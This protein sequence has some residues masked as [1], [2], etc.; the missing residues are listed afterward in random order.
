MATP[1]DAGG[2]DLPS[3]AAVV[4][5]LLDPSSGLSPTD[6]ADCAALTRAV[7]RQLRDTEREDLVEAYRA[8]PTDLDLRGMLTGAILEC[9]DDDPD[10]ARRL[11]QLT[12]SWTVSPIGAPKLVEPETFSPSSIP[13]PVPSRASVEPTAFAETAFAGPAS[14]AVTD[15]I[16][17]EVL[18]RQARQQSTSR[19]GSS[20][21]WI[22]AFEGEA[23]ALLSPRVEL[24]RRIMRAAGNPGLE[25][26]GDR[27]PGPR[28]WLIAVAVETWHKD[29]WGELQPATRSVAVTPNDDGFHLAYDGLLS[30]SAPI[31]RCPDRSQV[32][33][34]EIIRFSALGKAAA[35]WHRQHPEQDP[36]A[37]AAAFAADG[38]RRMLALLCA[39]ELTFPD[40]DLGEVEWSPE[41]Q[42]VIVQAERRRYETRP[43]PDM[44]DDQVIDWIE[45]GDT[46]TGYALPALTGQQ[47][48]ALLTRT[49]V[50]V[51]RPR[52]KNWLGRTVAG[53]PVWRIGKQKLERTETRVTTRS[54]YLRPD[55]SGY[56]TTASSGWSYSEQ[57]VEHD[58][59]HVY[60]SDTYATALQ[61]HRFTLQRDRR[62]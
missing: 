9:M 13:A 57:V 36:R 59:H 37:A 32:A 23:T 34:G 62:Q 8:A 1:Y 35:A 19:L 11:D 21:T 44:T 39:H 4:V 17:L 12:E 51:V 27:R 20:A 16:E 49:S 38:D 40:R 6:D 54:T 29:A 61:E 48:A 26:R 31:S 3:L 58:P 18:R 14:S 28:G 47:F 45:G 53:D 22:L 56:T 10:F 46:D 43:R 60:A 55:G 33:A 15:G 24:F 25:A 41:E 2:L 52:R 42:Y 5:G 30:Q 50:P 7:R